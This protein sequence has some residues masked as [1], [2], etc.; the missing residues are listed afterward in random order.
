MVVW[1]VYLLTSDTSI[2]VEHGKGCLRGNTFHCYSLQTV[3]ELTLL[4]VLRGKKQVT[5]LTGNVQRPA[6]GVVIVLTAIKIGYMTLLFHLFLLL[7]LSCIT[8]HALS[9]VRVIFTEM[10]P[11]TESNFERCVSVWTILW[12]EP[13]KQTFPLLSVPNKVVEIV[14]LSMRD[15]KNIQTIK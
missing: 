12:T 6:W 9:I 4:Q 13:R 1:G 3:V 5:M 10:C 15:Y 14:I 7:P 8:D 11:V 2:Y